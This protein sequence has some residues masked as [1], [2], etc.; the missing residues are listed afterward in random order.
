MVDVS[1]LSYSRTIKEAKRIPLEELASR[2][3]EL[4]TGSFPIMVI[5][6]QGIRSIKACEILV[7]K[8]YFNTNN[9][10]G[11]HECWPGHKSNLLEGDIPEKDLPPEL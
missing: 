10:S 8:G 1:Q 7:K 5:S 2:I 4:P 6:E 11:G 9:I 3:S